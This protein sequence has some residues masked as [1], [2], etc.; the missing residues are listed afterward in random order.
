MEFKTVFEA[1]VSPLDR[2]VNEVGFVILESVPGGFIKERVQAL[3]NN[4][5]LNTTVKPIHV[6]LRILFM[7]IEGWE[8]QHTKLF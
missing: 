3:N 7:M 5:L 6:L 8:R 4:Y 2:G 1:L